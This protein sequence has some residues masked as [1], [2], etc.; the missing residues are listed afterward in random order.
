M[1]GMSLAAYGVSIAVVQA[2][3]IRPILRTLGEGRA[4]F[5]GLAFNTACLVIYGLITQGWMVWVMVPISAIGAVVAPAMQG[6]MS[7]AAGA[8]QQGELQGVLASISALSMVLSPLMMTQAFFWATRDGGAVW[9]P[10]AP[11]LLSAVLMATALAIY[12]GAGRARAAEA[13]PAE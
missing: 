11:F 12:I 10:G 2:G 9:L 1:V 5:W 13:T 8:D 3:L 7:R 6:V 4:V